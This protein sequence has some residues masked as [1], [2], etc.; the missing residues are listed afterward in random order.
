MDLVIR[1]GT[2]F[3][4]D[5]Q[6]PFAVGSGGCNSHKVEGDGVTPIGV[7]PFRQIF[8]RADR[9]VDLHTLLPVT[10]INP[11]LGW[12]DDATDACYNQLITLPF[13]GSYEDLY[14]EDNIYDVILVVGYNDQPVIPGKG[15]VIFVH[16]AR[17]SFEPTKGCVAFSLLDLLSILHNASIGSNLIVEG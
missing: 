5:H 16:V 15:S 11:S 13:N 8:V 1:N 7:F 9:V 4:G 3:W 12:C 14:R 17:D 6:F 2:A 10:V